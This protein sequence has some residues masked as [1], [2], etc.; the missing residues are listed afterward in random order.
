[1]VASVR[2]TRVAFPRPAITFMDHLIADNVA[3]LEQGMQLLQQLSP[4]LYVRPCATCFNSSIGGHI[5]HNADHYEQFL[6]GFGSGRIDYDARSRRAEIEGDPAVAAAALGELRAGLEAL[7]SDN[8]DRA[9]E[10][11]MDGG[12]SAAWTKT[13]VRREL[14]FLISH[15]IHH[16]ALI[17][18]IA[19]AHGYTEL[20][21]GFGV[22]PSTLKH[23]A[24]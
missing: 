17:V 2:L 11:K 21:P 4:E 14:Q 9:L 1:M 24:A 23:R 20:P 8:L 16:H 12:A 5:R 13:S 15:T 19:G 10:V 3:C 22:A 18:A 7:A 6:A